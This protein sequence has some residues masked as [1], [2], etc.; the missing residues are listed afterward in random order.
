MRL[1]VG[2]TSPTGFFFDGSRTLS[3]RS[4]LKVRG[5]GR[6]A[7]RAATQRNAATP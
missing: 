2:S 1:P 4:G 5:T 6:A 7:D 3:R